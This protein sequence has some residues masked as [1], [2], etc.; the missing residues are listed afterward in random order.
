MIVLDTN[1]ISEPMRIRPDE[2]VVRWMAE[3]AL[4]E[5]YVTSV[6]EA[7]MRYGY[8]VLPAGRKR[9]LLEQQIDVVFLQRFRDRVLT[10]DSA[11]ATILA[12]IVVEAGQ[13][14]DDIDLFDAEIAAIALAHRAR[15]AT[16][17]VKHFAPYGVDLIDPWA[18]E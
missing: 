18:G 11:A 3:Q 6:S 8:E 9:T 2:A 14:M 13:P 16:R 12:R 5:V 1:V 7:E 15:V 10:F 17:N 4:G